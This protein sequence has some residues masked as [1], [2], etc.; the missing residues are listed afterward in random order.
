MSAETR[1]AHVPSIAWK[2]AAVVWALVI[3]CLSTGEFGL[4]FTEPLAASALNFLHLTILALDLGVMHLFV[5]K[6]APLTEYAVFPVLL[7]ASS[8]E[9]PFPWHP[10]WVL[11]CFLIIL[12]YSLTDEYRKRFVP[13]RN[14]SLKD[15][16]IDSIGG[17]MGIMAY[18]IN[19]FGFGLFVPLRCPKESA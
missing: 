3:F 4:S 5:H 9:Q 15:C 13:R 14:A 16:G 12:V 17:A 6:A 1:C 19:P 7:C 8:K 18:Y 2:V 11:R 10:R